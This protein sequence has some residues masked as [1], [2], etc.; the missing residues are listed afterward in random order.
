MADVKVSVGNFKDIPQKTGL[1]DG[2]H[3]ILSCSACGT[4]LVDIW[5]VKA[6]AI[7]PKTG[8]VFQWKGKAICYACGDS[9]FLQSWEGK[10][11]LGCIS[12]DAVDPDDS[13]IISRV[14]KVETKGDLIIFHTVKG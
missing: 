10:Y 14:T 8:K 3:V 6:N 4:A 5:I 12:N 7:N 9:S 1:K 11:A 2:G 13:K